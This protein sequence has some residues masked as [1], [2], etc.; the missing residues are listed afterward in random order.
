MSLE[1]IAA[2]LGDP[3]IVPR[4]AAEIALA[5][6]ADAMYP[7]PESLAACNYF[8]VSETA[9]MLDVCTATATRMFQDELGVLKLNRRAARPGRGRRPHVTLRIPLYL[10]ERRRYLLDQERNRRNLES[11]EQPSQ[12][13][14]QPFLDKLDFS[15]V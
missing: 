8:T 10:I 13:R 12:L 4:V 11:Q 5:R 1:G 15:D 2:Q 14:T 6:E 7:A 9:N 3:Y